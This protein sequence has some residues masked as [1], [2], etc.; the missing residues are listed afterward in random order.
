MARIFIGFAADGYP[1]YGSFFK[2]PKTGEVRK[3][4]S[5][6]TLK[7]GTREETAPKDLTVPNPGGKHNGMYNSDWEW[8]DAGDLDA[9]NGMTVNG[10]YGYYVID[11]FP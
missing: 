8:T 2:D 9:C 5:G 11:E 1:I 3:A 7:K 6:Y 4:R 10:Q